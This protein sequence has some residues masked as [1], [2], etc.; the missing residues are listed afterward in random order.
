MDYFQML[1]LASHIRSS[2]LK[3]KHETPGGCVSLSISFG[4]TWILA[5]WMVFR[6]PAVFQKTVC[7]ATAGTAEMETNSNDPQSGLASVTLR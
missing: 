5:L 3:M 2:F 7:T 6:R 1:L 4:E